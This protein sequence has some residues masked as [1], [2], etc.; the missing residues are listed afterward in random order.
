M[1]GGKTELHFFSFF[2]KQRET[3]LHSC[4]VP[5]SKNKT[6]RVVLRVTPGLRVSQNFSLQFCCLQF[7]RLQFCRLQFCL[8][9]GR[10]ETYS[11][12]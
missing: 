4:V 9:D 5:M 12:H 8:S 3:E 2:F 7:C 10:N 1:H 11:V 6:N